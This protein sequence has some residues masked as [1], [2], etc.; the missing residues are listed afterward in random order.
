MQLREVSSAS[1]NI[2]RVPNYVRGAEFS[3]TSLLGS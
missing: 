3:S 2:D 1:L